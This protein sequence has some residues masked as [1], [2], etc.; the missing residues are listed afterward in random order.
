MEET[1]GCCAFFQALIF[2]TL[3]HEPKDL[4]KFVVEVYKEINSF[5]KKSWLHV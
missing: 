2:S 5:I 3:P 4:K 1:I